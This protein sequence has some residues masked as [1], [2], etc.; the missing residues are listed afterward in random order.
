MPKATVT[1]LTETPNHNVLTAECANP[2]CDE[3]IHRT[4]GR[5]RPRDYHDEDCRRA[6]ADV[7]RRLE[8]RLEHYK[9]QVAILSE[10]YAAYEKAPG[11]GETSEQV[12]AG[13]LT[14]DQ[15]RA[16]RE[17]VS[18]VEGAAPFLRKHDGDFAAQLIELFDAVAPVVRS[19]L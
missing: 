13:A 5:G 1:R 6:T 2:R 16:A 11:M 10:R 9:E 7:K 15:I 3:V 14:P 17:A 8:S 19:H 18:K 12:D 4:G